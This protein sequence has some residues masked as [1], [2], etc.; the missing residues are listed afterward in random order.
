MRA[1]PR[2]HEV[3]MLR[4]VVV[5]LLINWITPLG[6]AGGA[7]PNQDSQLI[8]LAEAF[9]REFKALGIPEFTPDYQF[10]LKAIRGRNDLLRQRNF[11]YTFRTRLKGIDPESLGLE[12]KIVYEQLEYELKL[13]QQR[14]KLELD[15]RTHT[16]APHPADGLHRLHN[17]SK[18]YALYV[19]QATSRVMTPQE[20]QHLGEREVKRVTSKIR[21]IQK[22][23]GYEGRDAQFYNYLNSDAFIIRDQ[24]TIQSSF[25]EM[26][27]TVHA[28]L[29]DFV[30]AT[31]IAPLRISAIDH[32]D[33]NTPPG[34][35]HQGT[36][37]YNFYA[38]RFNR[39]TLDWLFLHEGVPGH[40]YQLSIKGRPPLVPELNQLFFYPGF[41]EGW[42][43]YCEDWGQEL[44]LYKDPYQELGKWEWDL[45]RSV[46]LVIDVGIH[47]KGWSK[48]K[49]LSY[50]KRHVPNQDG[51]AEREIDRIIRWPGQVISYKAG[52]AYLLEL[53]QQVQAKLGRG[54]DLKRFHTL[55]LERG[56]LPLDVLAA[57]V[58]RGL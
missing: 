26:N 38:G 2:F 47:E 18:W 12:A 57:A 40:H 35:Y 25:E 54:F 6:L 22:T 16:A 50:W 24:G 31:S 45:V 32:P 23:M 42:G 30:E 41:A 27:Q 28:R 5:I 13:N 20:V 11:F 17:H 34:Y 36:F 52:E 19:M 3:N 44:G 37:F 48:A 9:A 21:T 53:R 51:I 8:D 43:V 1:N 58:K 33:K 4:C 7:R 14:V 55:V 56:A 15:Y 10:N 46:R 39:R 29:G 49:A